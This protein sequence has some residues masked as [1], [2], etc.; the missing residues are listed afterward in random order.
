MELTDGG[1]MTLKTWAENILN[2]AIDQKEVEELKQDSK[3][4][5]I[6]YCHSTLLVTI[7]YP[8]PKKTIWIAIA[9]I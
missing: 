5:Y 4:S 9:T 8:F 7:D 6:W 3:M 2:L 1:E